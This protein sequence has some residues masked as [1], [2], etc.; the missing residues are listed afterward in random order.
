MILFVLFGYFVLIGL[1]IG[2]FGFCLL[3]G[4]AMR[5]FVVCGCLCGC[6]PIVLCDL[7]N[8]HGWVVCCLG[9]R[10]C[11]LKFVALFGCCC[12]F[13]WFVLL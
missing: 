1:L 12:F 8:V 11:V 4:F 13:V 10:C 6:F 7:V 2:L 5:L 3:W 9:L